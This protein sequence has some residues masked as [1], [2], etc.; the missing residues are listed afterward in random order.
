[1][2]K[3]AAI[4][5]SVLCISVGILFAAC[6]D[7]GDGDSGNGGAHEHSFGEWTITKVATCTEKGERE[8]VCSCGEKVT[9]ETALVPHTEAVDSAVA[10]TCTQTG[11]TEGKHCSV[12]SEVLVAQTVVSA[13]GHTSSEWI[14][15]TNATCENKGGRHKECTVCHAT[16]ETEEISATGHS[17]VTDDAVA[18]TCTQTGLT[19]GTHCSVCNKVLVA[20]T[21]V[22]AK[23][24][25]LIN[26]P[27]K[28]P[29]CTETGHNAYDTC[30]RCSY[31]T[32]VEL[33][34]THVEVIDRAVE[35]TCTKSGLTEGK[36]C[37]RCNAVLVSQTVLPAGHNI[38][39]GT[40]T[41]CGLTVATKLS[42][43][44]N[45]D[46]QSYSV[47]G[48][49][50]E[51]ATNFIIPSTHNGLPVI[52]INPQAFKNNL[53][54]VSVIIPESVVNIGYSA[55][56]GCRNLT[57][58]VIPSSV[59]EMQNSVFKDCVSLTDVSLFSNIVSSAIFSGCTSLRNI[60]LPAGVTE[61]ASM[62]FYGC[63]AL[64][65]IDIPNGVTSIGNQAFDGCVELAEVTLSSALIAIGNSAFND[66]EKLTAVIFPDTLESIGENAFLNC[67]LVR[68]VLPETVTKIG[69]SAF[70]MP[71]GS[72]IDATGPV[73]LFKAL[74]Q[75]TLTS[76]T[77]LSGEITYGTFTDLGNLQ[78]LTIGRNVTLIENRAF[79][80]TNVLEAITVISGNAAYHSAG[81]CLIDT[82]NKVLIAGSINSV[83]PNDGTVTS[84]ADDAFT[85]LV[86]L[87]QIVIGSSIE[88]IG[89]G[90]FSECTDLATV[91]LY[92]GLTEIKS[93]AFSD[94][95]VSAVYFYGTVADWCNI[96]GK[97]NYI[98]QE[99]YTLY[100]NGTALSGEV[101]IPDGV[102]TINNLSFAYL[103]G[104]TK[105]TLPASVTSVGIG[106]FK[107]CT[108]LEELTILSTQISMLWDEA[109]LNC[110][111][112]KKVNIPSVA[113]WV[114]I[115]F[116]GES[117]SCNPLSNGGNLYVNGECQQ[118]LVIPEGVY[119]INGRAFCGSAIT[120]VTFAKTVYE[121]GSAVF[122]NC[123]L[124]T[125]VEIPRSTQTINS[126]L[127]EGCTSLT[128]VIIPDTVS[129]IEYDA[130]K[131]CI[132]LTSI[133]IPSKV[134]TIGQNAFSG[135]TSLENII[136]PDSVTSMGANVFENCTSLASVVIGAGLVK[137]PEYAFMGCSLL[138]NVV[139]PDTVKSIGYGAF[140]NCASLTDITLSQN[141]TALLDGL[142]VG[143]TALTQITI[144]DSITTIGNS[145]FSGCYSLESIV[146]PDT[147]TAIGS[148]AFMDCT[149]LTNVV[150]SGALTTIKSSAF[151]GCTALT[152]VTI[153]VSVTTIG[154]RA[155]MNCTSL[156]TI[157]YTG[158]VEQWKKIDFYTS[159]NSKWD[160]NAGEYTVVCS[161]GTLDKNNN[162][163]S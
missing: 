153:P 31:T 23:G 86:G 112:L 137:I 30:S 63:T 38:V 20:Q 138:N 12:C 14:T 33:P 119:H 6:G 100:I 18:P 142:F 110:I 71:S 140:K 104:I 40:C 47:R 69:D 96:V 54:I 111:A 152:D 50:S 67:N 17:P 9:E 148:S 123:K 19:E 73:A 131:N 98:V 35:P 77:V 15:D 80:S 109:F 82:E 103:T 65:E 149:S 116:N 37:S 75:N 41:R 120:K 113:A 46:E 141:V 160:L 56:E 133:T 90:A 117:G 78:T 127:F 156:T 51:T 29:N 129:K 87:T 88:N 10:P 58:V 145:V 1:M 135:C 44:L 84:I 146:V 151:N 52:A 74:Y 144:P 64:R 122:K 130:F 16:L 155:F 99:N 95:P 34:I 3:I 91:T 61:I 94:C 121:F 59:T 21:V 124:L 79:Y 25:D 11:L 49:G 4:I 68:V 76:M 150:L 105:V 8:K 115:G 101:V 57:A 161:D 85:R 97:E 162:L 60:T 159:R 39:D 28:E 22:S 134:K 81:N 93:N 48:I 136:I 55:F 2:K 143:C 45:G 163:L 106:A 42:F 125:E 154:S 126:S 24:H 72:L 108:S 132:S 158:T 43:A 7:N 118:E 89:N 92:S 13:T 107:G 66:C 5:F 27:A 128:T 147:V 102:R 62:A 53:K 83:I 36:H 139:V 32:Y 114:D 157:H 26:H 70:K